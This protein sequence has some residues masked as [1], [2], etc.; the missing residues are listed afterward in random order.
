VLGVRIFKF[1]N[2]NNA[3]VTVWE[4]L[5]TFKDPVLSSVSKLMKTGG[6][7]FVG[8]GVLLCM[9]ECVASFLRLVSLHESLN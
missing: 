8:E 2:T 3:K 4:V 9:C 6:W 5:K 1:G 7:G